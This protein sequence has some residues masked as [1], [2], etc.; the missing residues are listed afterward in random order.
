VYYLTFIKLH[1]EKIVTKGV[2]PKNS[3]IK[4]KEFMEMFL[5]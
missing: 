1:D 5:N 3:K 4:K 2:N